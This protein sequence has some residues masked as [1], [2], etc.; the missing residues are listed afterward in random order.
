MFF[1]AKPTGKGVIDGELG[2][3]IAPEVG[4]PEEGGDR[5]L[6]DLL[7]PKKSRKG[8]EVAGGRKITPEGGRIKKEEDLLWFR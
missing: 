5:L 7:L 3:G 6:G 4:M 1:R 8:L 2:R